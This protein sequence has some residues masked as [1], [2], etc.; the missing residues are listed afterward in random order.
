MSIYFCYSD[1]VV[2]G[3]LLYAVFLTNLVIFHHVMKYRLKMSSIFLR[4]K[5]LFSFHPGLN[6]QVPYVYFVMHKVF[7]FIYAYM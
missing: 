5:E 1:N 3:E 4:Q 2:T 6:S 7:F